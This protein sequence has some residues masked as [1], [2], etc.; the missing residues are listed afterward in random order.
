MT[1]F[2]GMF[3]ICRTNAFSYIIGMMSWNCKNW[4]TLSMVGLG[5]FR[6]SFLLTI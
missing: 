2:E 1:N 5:L 3:G 4:D 6:K